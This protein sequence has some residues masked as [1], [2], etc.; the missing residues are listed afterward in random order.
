MF[1]RYQWGDDG[2]V[3]L[4]ASARRLFSH[5]LRKDWN[6]KK[7]IAVLPIATAMVA[8]FGASQAEAQLCAN[9]SGQVYSRAQCK[10]KETVVPGTPGPIG[11]AGPG[12]SNAP[13]TQADAANGSWAMTFVDTLSNETDI[14]NVSFDVNGN[15]ISPGACAQ[16]IGLS[17]MEVP[18]AQAKLSL[19]YGESCGFQFRL[20][21][22]NNAQWQGTLSMDR[23]KSVLQGVAGIALSATTV[24]S[25]ATAIGTRWG[26]VG[27]TGTVQSAS[28]PEIDPMMIDA[29][30]K[31]Y[32]KSLSGE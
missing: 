31:A 5:T 8:V 4:S 21:K 32:M 17:T 18:I 11:P 25:Y 19:I 30:A 1:S 9:K 6:M 20:T 15:F 22:D 12:I 13:C 23:T 14:C 2:E 16:T 28:L 10:A 26:A 29:A 3:N 24:R 7:K 27:A